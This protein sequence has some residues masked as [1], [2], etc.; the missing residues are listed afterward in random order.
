VH[1]DREVA[2]ELG[3]RAWVMLQR[4]RG[5]RTPAL[6]TVVPG[7]TMLQQQTAELAAAGRTDAEIAAVLDISPKAVAEHLTAAG[8]RLGVSGR[9][10]LAD[11]LRM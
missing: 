9:D 7:L 1:W 3:T 4:C 6:R 2:T 10:K 5:V 8:E 11:L